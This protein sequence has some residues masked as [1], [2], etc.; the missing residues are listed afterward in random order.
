MSCEKFVGCENLRL[1]HN[2]TVDPRLIGLEATQTPFVANCSSQRISMFAS[3]IVQALIVKGREQPL[4]STGFEPQLIDYTFNPTR[5]DQDIRI[6][7]VVPKYVTNIGAYQIKE[8]HSYTVIYVGIDDGK[9]DYFNLDSYTKGADG[10]GYMNIIQNEHMLQTD[11]YVPKDVVFSH[12][13]A[14][15]GNK[16]MLG[17]NAKVA[18]MS[19]QEVAEDAVVISESLADRMETTAIGT[20][21]IDINPN[22]VPLNI[23]GTEDLYKILPD[24]GEVVGPDGI[25][26]ALRT[27]SDESIP[28]DTRPSAMTTTQ[29]HDDKVY[30]KPGASILDIE[31]YMNGSKQI[32]TPDYI[33]TQPK[34]Y[35]ENIVAY[36]TGL[37]DT[38]MQCQKSHMDLSPAFISLITHAMNML[39]GYGKK[40]KNI[41]RTGKVP[42]FMIK[43]DPIEFMH[44]IVTYQHPLKVTKG[45]KITGKSGDKGVVAEIWKTEDMPRDDFGNV[46]DIIIAS[47]AV[48]NRMNPPQLLEQWINYVATFVSTRAK[49][50]EPQAGYEYIQSLVR[51]V[52]PIYSTILHEIVTSKKYGVEEYL[53]ETFRDGIVFVCPPFLKTINPKLIIALRDEFDIPLSPVEFN[54]R[55]GAGNLIRRVRTRKN[56][57]IGAKYIY[58]LCKVP[59]GRSSGISYINQMKLPVRQHSK[60]RFFSPIGEVPIR[61]GEDEIRQMGMATSPETTARFLSLYSNSYAGL[62]LTID[63]LLTAKNPSAIMSIPISTDELNESNKAIGILRHFGSNLGLDF[64]NVKIDEHHPFTQYHRNKR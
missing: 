6:L 47:E 39:L 46:A 21:K 41:H 22:T 49:E 59:K 12:S 28:T 58:Q 9:V 56:V 61:T 27:I 14:V 48:V 31:V 13:P 36:Y 7:A 4:I 23:H 29:I 5:R 43:R 64:K 50:M 53:E 38:Y 32:K 8:C 1:T 57:V 11:R 20:V 51:R 44:I 2:L 3:N 18:Y 60:A 52:T 17:L 45:T 25:L 24:I 42:T 63:L 10:F 55:D 15:E 30:V 19:L 54:I 34:A 33:F 16:Y 62:E 26:C 35:W 40:L 37:Y